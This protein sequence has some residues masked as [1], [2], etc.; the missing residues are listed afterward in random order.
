[1]SLG[2]LQATSRPVDMKERP[3]SARTASTTEPLA[4]DKPKFQSL[5]DFD[6]ALSLTPDQVDLNWMVDPLDSDDDFYCY[7]LLDVETMSVCSDSSI[8]A[9]AI[10]CDTKLK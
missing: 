2:S 1:M 8:V 10:T 9:M 3:K 5:F 6:D 4:I 7:D